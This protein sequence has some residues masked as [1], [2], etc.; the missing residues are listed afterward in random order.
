MT[1]RVSAIW[2]W[3]LGPGGARGGAEQK[4]LPIA[5]S[6]GS[7]TAFRYCDYDVPFWARK[8]TRPGRFHALGDPPTQYWALCPEAAWAKLIRHEDLR[9]EAELDLVRMPIWVAR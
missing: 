6:P 2:S 9:S 5:G 3:R 1:P 8:N 4:D 7:L